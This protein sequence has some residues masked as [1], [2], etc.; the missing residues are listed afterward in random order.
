MNTLDVAAAAWL[1][2]GG[3]MWMGGL[4]SAVRR[5]TA[6]TWRVT[7]DDPATPLDDLVSI[8]IPA[9]DEVH[10]IGAAVAS[11]LAQDHRHVEV[12]VLDDGSTDG[13]GGVLAAIDDPR[14]RVITGGG[15]PLPDGWL[16]KPWACERAGRAARGRWLL[17]ID[18]DVRLAPEAVSRAVAY[19]AREGAD[20]VSGFGEMVVGSLGERLIQP[21]VG[22]MILAANPLAEVNDP[23]KP[24]KAL[25]NGQFLLFAPG[26]WHALG[27]HGAVAGDVVDDV[28]FARRI[29]ESGRVLRLVHMQRL[30]ACR[31]YQSGA[32]AWR[33]WRK[34]LFVGIHRS[35]GLLGLI[36]L[37][38]LG[39]VIGPY[40]VV[41]AALLGVV[42]GWW[43]ALAAVSVFGQQGL[44]AY[45]DTVFHQP[46]LMGQL[47][48]LPGNVLVLGIFVDS[49]I[50]TTRGKARW[51]GRVVG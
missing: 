45:L 32:D 19:A 46:R 50:A 48:H 6:N 5:V 15:G 44:R 7:P 35:W 40:A 34:N 17:F 30:Y 12:V 43:G 9:R 22:G 21:A 47:L 33:G 39:A 41:L 28:A 18:A 31:M 25:A 8:V 10:N 1:G 3:L 26:V 29:K 11:A 20:L 2:L 23:E 14:L 36:V 16:G 49:A 37:A 27:G 38:S 51:K 24:K 42:P 13:T 4:A